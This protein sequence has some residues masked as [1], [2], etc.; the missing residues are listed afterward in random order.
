M[1][2]PTYFARRIRGNGTYESRCLECLTVVAFEQDQAELAGHEAD[3]VC[4]PIRRYQL[5]EDPSF[6]QRFA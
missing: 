2:E 3:H 6:R 5:S 1:K 4:D